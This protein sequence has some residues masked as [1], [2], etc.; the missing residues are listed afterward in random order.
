M[1]FYADLLFYFA[2]AWALFF[3]HR[4]TRSTL[5]LIVLVAWSV[6]Q[7]TLAE[8]GFYQVLDE[9]P[10]R[11][12]LALGPPLV[13]ILFMPILPRYRKWSSGFDM[14]CLLTIHVLRVP[15]EVFLHEAWSSGLVP[16][17]ITWSGT[18]WD[19]LSGISAA[20]LLAYRLQRPLPRALMI[21]WNIIAMFLLLNVVGTA[22]LSLPTPMQQLNF[23]Q[24][25]ILVTRAPYILLPA[26]IVPIVLFAHMA[27]LVQLLTDT[28]E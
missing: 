3:V 12:L 8:S 17:Q 16:E 23:D 24:P 11:P 25:L 10:P 26:V 13:A 4:A 21:A 14:V 19:I 28:S 20:F 9:L 5:L 7:V 2:L 27:A 1:P 15:I 18:N 6:V 22:L